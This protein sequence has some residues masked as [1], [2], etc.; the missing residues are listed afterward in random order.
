ML[1]LI[2]LF[3]SIN[4]CA[5]IFSISKVD[6]KG[7]VEAA[8]EKIES[9]PQKKYLLTLDG[10]NI[11]LE[12]FFEKCLNHQPYCN[13]YEKYYY[14]KSEVKEIFSNSLIGLLAHKVRLYHSPMSECYPEDSDP[15]KTHG[16][17]A[18]F[19]DE[20]GSFMGLAV[21]TGNGKYFVINYSGY[22]R[23]LPLM[24]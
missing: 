16:D 15:G 19:Y 24:I 4:N 8:I 13:L 2:L 7:C 11:L 22:K 23:Y 21:Y 9:L 1:G 17:V 3:L 20:R 12:E 18:E 5:T 14:W 6:P 10:Q